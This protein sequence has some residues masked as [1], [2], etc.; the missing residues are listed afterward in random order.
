VCWS[1]GT[2]TR[3]A[4]P[5]FAQR[6]TTKTIDDVETSGWFTE[7]FTCAELKTLRA[8]ERLPA[9]RPANRRYDG[10]YDVATFDE[11]L[12]LAADART[13]S[14][15]PVG[16]YPETKHPSYFRSIGLP[17][18]EPLLKSLDDHG[19]GDATAPVFLQSFETS[20]L[21]QLATSTGHRLIQLIKGTGA[22]YDLT[23]AD[24]PRSYSDL[25]SES[26]LKTIS[27]YAYGVGLPKSVMI[28]RDDDGSLL[29]PTPVIEHAHNSGLA[30]HGFTF[31]R[32]NVFLPL[33]YRV[34]T[35][36]DGAGDLEGEI[37]AF[38]DAGL[39][40]IFADQSD[41][42]RTVSGRV[43]TRVGSL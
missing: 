18:E 15:T 8:C 41:V 20:N 25:V 35:E 28:P 17:I 4:R 1:P 31:R 3:S 19:Y 14:G 37:T 29:E 33:Q 36:P 22:P 43:H 11:I 24:D 7:D 32:E 9:V 34:G 13:R 30:V 2:R 6:R 5:E 39:D 21:R 10:Q 26:G 38:V 42:A 23:V 16:V 12:E 40:G 27:G